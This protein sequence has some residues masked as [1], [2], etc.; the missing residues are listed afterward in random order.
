MKCAAQFLE[1]L[2]VELQG[3]RSIRWVWCQFSGRVWVSGGMRSRFGLKATF[4]DELA[5]WG[6]LHPKDH[7]RV[8]GA[9]SRLRRDTEDG[10]EVGVRLLEAPGVWGEFDLM[11]SRL[12][13]GGGFGEAPEDCWAC[14]LVLVSL[15]E[16]AA[17]RGVEV[18]EGVVAEAGEG[19]GSVEETGGEGVGVLTEDVRLLARKVLEDNWRECEL[20]MSRIREVRSGLLQPQDRK[21]ARRSGSMGGRRLKGSGAAMSM[22][23]FLVGVFLLVT[24][25]LEPAFLLLFPVLLLAAFLFVIPWGAASIAQAVLRKAGD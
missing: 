24:M 13:C 23:A 2:A 21:F 1:A 4:M 15:E 18:V 19:V 9:I 10:V 25:L 5:A 8:M 22:V 14:G 17:V 12:G 7:D 11:V 16:V 3:V 6:L 20:R